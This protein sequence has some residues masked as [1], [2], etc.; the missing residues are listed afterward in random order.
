M[1]IAQSKEIIKKNRISGEREGRF[2]SPCRR[3][4]EPPLPA[5]VGGVKGILPI[6]PYQSKGYVMRKI[7]VPVLGTL[8]ILAVAACSSAPTTL[9]PGEYEKTHRTTDAAG[10]EVEQ[11]TRTEVYYDAE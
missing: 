5:G 1:V 3:G 6:N 7:I 4:R 10:N 8:S 11:T 2:F 9:P